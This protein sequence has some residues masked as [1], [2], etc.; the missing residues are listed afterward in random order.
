MRFKS[1]WW[2][3]FSMSHEVRVLSMSD[4]ERKYK[5]LQHSE[6]SSEI[7]RLT[8]PDF[9]FQCP[10]SLAWIKAVTPV[11]KS[12]QVSVCAQINP[13]IINVSLQSGQL[14]IGQSCK[15]KWVE[16]RI[17]FLPFLASSLKD[18]WDISKKVIHHRKMKN[19]SLGKSHELQKQCVNI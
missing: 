15:R 8:K 19:K 3:H 12:A 17:L 2:K 16:T 4:L 14:D 18:S 1:S 6:S 13:W 9:I 10:G 7:K 5:Y 11:R